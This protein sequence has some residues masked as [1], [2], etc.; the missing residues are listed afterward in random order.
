M[1]NLRGRLQQQ[2]TQMPLNIFQDKDGLPRI[3]LTEPNG[4]SLEV[5]FP[6]VFYSCCFMV[7][8]VC[9]EPMFWKSV[10]P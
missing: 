4:S 9:F 7:I 5:G 8:I 1:S 2:P 3:V 6:S 10:K